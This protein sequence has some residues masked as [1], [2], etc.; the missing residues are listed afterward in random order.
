MSQKTDDRVAGISGVLVRL[1]R[2]FGPTDG[3]SAFADELINQ[4]SAFALAVDD[5]AEYRN[6]GEVARSLS[7]LLGDGLATGTDYERQQVRTIADRLL[8]LLDGSDGGN[9]FTVRT[10]LV[11]PVAPTSPR[12]NQR[13]ALY[14]DQPALQAWLGNALRHAG[15]VTVD[16]EGLS[17][18]LKAGPDDYPAAIIAD[19]DLCQHDSAAGAIIAT[20]RQRFSPAPHLF[21]LASSGDIPARLEA[22]RLGATRCFAKPLDVSRLISVLKGVT[23]QTPVRP[24]RV[25]LAEDDRMLGELYQMALNHAGMEAVVTH[26]PLRVPELI[27]HF[28]PDVVVSDIYMPGCNGLELLTLLRQDDLLADT[29]IIF[30][31]SDGDPHCQLEALDLGG[32]DFLVKPVDIAVFVATIRARAKRARALKRSRGEY[33]RLIDR[34]REMERHLPES[35]PA[36]GAAH[37]EVDVLLPDLLSLDGYEVDEPENGV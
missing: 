34:M 14:L 35:F 29:P 21:C 1:L 16:L 15:F 25:L 4:L 20:L 5:I 13:V 6:A 22:V 36:T 8:V 2:E 19:L 12:A 28:M 11:T 18:L 7:A 24:F 27:A 30:L 33:R 23:A 26:N 31:S 3:A 9:P 32:D 37:F 10:P 17:D